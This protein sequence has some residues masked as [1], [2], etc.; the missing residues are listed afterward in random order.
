MLLAASERSY[1]VVNSQLEPN[2]HHP[3]FVPR[4]WNGQPGPP[5]GQYPHS[6][7]GPPP[8]PGIRSVLVNAF[9]LVTDD[10]P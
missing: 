1:P 7:Y 4:M 2:T 6:G 8:G 3:S 5:P 10:Y 9:S